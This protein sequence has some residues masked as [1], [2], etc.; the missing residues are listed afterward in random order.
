MPS[1]KA[2]RRRIQS[3]KNTQKITRAMKMI[4]SVKL[5]RAQ[6]KIL[7]MRPYAKRTFDIINDILLEVEKGEHPLIEKREEKKI[8]LLVFTSDRGLCG[9]FNSNI[10]RNTEKFIEEKR[11]EG[12]EILISVIG[13]KGFNYFDYHKIKVE[14]YFKDILVE[15]S[16]EKIK[17][18]VA[19]KIMDQF[20]E[21]RFDAFYMIYN[22][23]KSVISQ[24]VTVE[25]LLPIEPVVKE[26]REVKDFIFEPNKTEIL[27][28]LLPMYVE[29]E[30]YRV[31]LESIASEYGAR[32]TAMDNATENAEEMIANLT[33]QFNKA[34]QAMITKELM[35]IIGGAEAQ[36]KAMS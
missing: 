7:A 33:L 35:D 25:K 6:A 11:E 22:E 12:K 17:V 1:L 31:L 27:N 28:R 32:M 3:V 19:S 30:L 4:A 26:E 24:K 36:R 5:R 15:P 16:L 10:L 21:R 23:F 20:I 14:H 8:M 9:S 18:D 34:R 29:I 2:I 13:K